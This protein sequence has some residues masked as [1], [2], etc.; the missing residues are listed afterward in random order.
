MMYNLDQVKKFNE[1]TIEDYNNSLKIEE[2]TKVNLIEESDTSFTQIGIRPLIPND[3]FIYKNWHPAL[4]SIGM[5]VANGE[6]DFLIKNILN[7]KEIDKIIL[8]KSELLEFPKYVYEFRKATI[9]ISLD[10][11]M[12]ISQKL[13]HRIQYKNYKEILDCNYELNFIPGDIM[14]NKIIILDK[15]A[16]LWEKQKFNNKFTNKDEKIDIRIAPRGDKTDITIRSV[17]KI[18][19]LDPELIK[20]IEVKEDVEEKS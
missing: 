19:H 5:Q 7:N 18:K 1:Y 13:M 6:R 9:L 20:I 14:K 3:M 8:K 10:F 2:M 16:I 11:F 4:P 12:E 15:E 17:N